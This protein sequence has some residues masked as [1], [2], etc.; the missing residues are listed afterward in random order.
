MKNSDRKPSDTKRII[1]NMGWMTFDKVFLLILNLLV[2]VKIANYYG[3]STYGSY[4]YA[5]SVVAIVE[6]LVNFV[7]GRVVKK[8]YEGNDPEVVVATATMSR[9]LFSAIS[10]IVGLIF[11]LCYRG[12]R[13]FSIMFAVLLLNAVVT[14][15]RFG[16]ANRFEYLLKSKI[17]VIASDISA[18]I[19]SLLQLVAVHFGL[20]IIAI[21]VIAL[22]ASILNLLLISIQYRLEF[23]NFRF[24]KAVNGNLLKLF[25]KQ[26]TPLAIAASCAII[27]SRCDSVM[28]GN[29]L[30]TADVGI[31]SIAVKLISVVQIAI[32]PV[33]ES[34]YPKLIQLY[35]SNRKRYEEVYI[36]ATSILSWIYI[37]GVALSIVV[38]PFAFRFLNPE[39]ANAFGVYKIYVIGSFFMYNAALRA[40]HF[41]LINRGVI[42][43]YSQIIS[44]VLNIVLNWFLIKGYGLYG[45][46]TATAITQG[47]SLLFSN[48]FFKKDGREVFKWQVLALNPLRILPNY[49]KNR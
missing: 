27:Y 8:E 39:Y 36:R 40:G 21:S 20:S 35:N 31:Y 9:L 5:V 49:G 4:Q 34:V 38:L 37:L 15:L 10:A 33:R 42:L 26:S 23:G 32:A 43:T 2:T 25:V 30:S 1:I 47:V 19:G 7:D 48:L 18:T 13:S 28:V 12:T 45:A 11:I 3:S 22:I 41:T 44:V 6:I 24:S 17:I 29:M 46:A 14:D 16:M